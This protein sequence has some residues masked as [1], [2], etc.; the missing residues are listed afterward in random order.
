[1]LKGQFSR[2]FLE[3]PIVSDLENFGK[4]IR[5]KFAGKSGRPGMTCGGISGRFKGSEKGR[6]IENDYS[7]RRQAPRAVQKILFRDHIFVISVD[8]NP[9]P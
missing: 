5:G 2:R 3:N 6:V 7:A 1:L 9:V 4:P 8:I